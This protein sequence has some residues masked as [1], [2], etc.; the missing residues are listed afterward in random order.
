MDISPQTIR[1]TGFKTVKKGYDPQ[2]V[3][4][5]RTAVATAVETAQNQAAAMEA[6]ARAAVAKLQEVS[7]Q[8]AEPKEAVEPT[9]RSGDT[10]VISRTLLLAQRTADSTVAEARIEAESITGIAREE[11]SRV[12]DSARAM[13]AK[14]VDDSRFEARRAVE[15]ERMRAENEV[16]SLLA[17]RDFLLGDVD[18]LEHYLQAQRERLRDAAVQLQE[19]VDRVPGGLGDM[20]RPL[21]SASAEPVAAEPVVI[22]QVAG[23][24]GRAPNLPANRCWQIHPPQCSC[25]LPR[26]WRRCRSSRRPSAVRPRPTPSLRS[27]RRPIVRPI[28][29]HWRCRA[30]PMRRAACG[31]CSMRRLPARRRRKPRRAATT[32]LPRWRHRRRRS[33][34]TSR[35]AWAATNF[36]KRSPRPP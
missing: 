12:L 6:R 15:D 31:G 2:E 8:V 36:D 1:S 5:F 14:A 34:S 26:A 30:T 24:Q 19:L 9:R 23:P 10:E 25:R 7:Q 17:R 28:S 35:S 33:R 18:H 27:R 21:L 13:A 3:D 22:E 29:A 4:L 20:R 32:S 11:A 16:Q